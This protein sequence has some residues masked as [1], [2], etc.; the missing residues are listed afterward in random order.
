MFGLLSG[1]IFLPLLGAAV[2]LL[3]P[4]DQVKWARGAAMIFALAA[5]GLAGALWVAFQD[6]AFC[7]PEAH[8][9]FVERHTWYPAIGASFALGVDGLSVTMVLLAGLL[10]PLAMLVSWE[11]TERAHAFLALMLILEAAVMGA[12]VALD[13]LIFFLFWE[14]SLVPMGLIIGVWGGK[15]ARPAAIKFMLFTMGGSLGMFA[16]IQMI[17]AALGT[18]DIPA[19]LDAW[20]AWD[21][22]GGSGTYLG[23]DASL[24]KNLTFLAFGAAF[25]VKLPVWPLHIWL[26]DAHTEAPTGGSMLLAGILLKMGGYGFLRLLLPLFPEQS[27]D[28]AGL[29]GALGVI[30]IIMGALA[31]LGQRDLK[32]LVAYSS[33]SHMGFVLLGIA[34]AALA[35]SQVAVTAAIDGEILEMFAHGLSSPAMFLLVG[36]IYHR[37]G[38]RNLDELGGLWEAAPILSGLMILAAF[39]SLGLPGTGGFV[40]ELLVLRGIWSVFVWEA[41]L[42]AVGTIFLSGYVLK[43]L[44]GTLFGEVQP[45]DKRLEISTREIAAVLPLIVMLIFTGVLPNWILPVLNR[46]VMILLQ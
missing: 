44:Y 35:R 29:M 9:C 10:V 11:I 17:G 2:V 33:V 24:I 8:F 39:G 6:P 41:V 43:A 36:A 25:A 7:D 27:A 22:A 30:G 23:M 34:A 28:S 26:P 32:R 15:K 20:P 19:L 13:L 42:G 1:L 40:A 14:S 18:F 38:T 16:A 4:R 45:G 31:A 21:G 12:F 37:A 46:A 5:F 3:V